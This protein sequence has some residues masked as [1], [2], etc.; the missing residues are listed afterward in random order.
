[1]TIEFFNKKVNFNNGIYIYNTNNTGKKKKSKFYK[2][3][4]FP[5][6]LKNDDKNSIIIKGDNNFINKSIKEYLGFNK[7]F[8][9]VGSGRGEVSVYL[10]AGTNNKIFAL[11]PSIEALKCGY[12]FSEK[13]EI[14][15]IKY[16][17]AEISDD[18]FKSE[19]FDFVYC[20][21]AFHNNK[22]SYSDFKIISKYLKENGIIVLCLYN[23]FGR[24]RT[25]FRQFIYKYI[26]K[27]I[28]ILLDPYLRKNKNN[29][30]RRKAWIQ[31]QYES[32]IEYTY[33]Y[34][35][36]LKWFNKN[37]ID[38]VNFY[39][40]SFLSLNKNKFLEKNETGNFFERFCEQ[41]FMIFTKHGSEGGL[42]MIVGK[43]KKL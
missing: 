27:K 12:E 9:E 16:I 43:K 1:M 13:N 17:N 32:S 40:N 33:S 6:Y 34:D 4:L 29:I 39:P 37:N 11:D 35:E 2:T 19:K 24:L 25:K 15:N 3:Q 30:E 22:N 26:S 5:N 18:V 38:F 8:L 42:F 14:D 36:I 41:I 10:A 31:N 20:N 21:G 7:N 28:T 23:N